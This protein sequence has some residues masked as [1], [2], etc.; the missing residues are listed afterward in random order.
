MSHKETIH[1]LFIDNDT[2]AI[3][4]FVKIQEI[5]GN[6]DGTITEIKFLGNNKHFHSIRD[7]EEQK[8]EIKSYIDSYFNELDILLLDLLLRVEEDNNIIYDKDNTDSNYYLR[9]SL[10]SLEIAHEYKEKFKD[11]GKLIGFTSGLNA[12]NTLSKFMEFQRINSKKVSSEWLY[13]N[14]PRYNKDNSVKEK[15]YCPEV[16][17]F[18]KIHR[19][20][21][22]NSLECVHHQL[23]SWFDNQK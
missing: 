16:C 18:K 4:K 13:V 15:I 17:N 21:K 20:G 23:V 7:K 2:I 8:D 3:E 12:V 9:H 1:V 19:E 14:K 6:P 5:K 11:S 10:L 22:C